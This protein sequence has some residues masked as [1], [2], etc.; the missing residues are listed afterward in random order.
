[1]LTA[2]GKTGNRILPEQWKIADGRIFPLM[3]FPSLVRMICKPRISDKIELGMNYSGV[4][5]LLQLLPA[6]PT[7]CDHT[8]YER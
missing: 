7:G 5:L 6:A 8:K 3:P 1:M 2:H 4:L